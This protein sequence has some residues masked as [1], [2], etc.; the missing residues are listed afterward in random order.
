MTWEDGYHIEIL[1]V[2]QKYIHITVNCFKSQYFKCMENIWLNVQNQYKNSTCK[3]MYMTQCKRMLSYDIT[4]KY[5]ANVINLKNI[6][7]HMYFYWRS[8]YVEHIPD[9]YTPS[10][11]YLTFLL[12]AVDMEKNQVGI[13]GMYMYYV[14]NYMFIYLLMQLKYFVIDNIVFINRLDLSLIFHCKYYRSVL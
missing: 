10:E 12:I 1:E 6:A 9:L 4:S 7:R 5:A 8:K 14:F 3:Y 2:S 13:S 11:F